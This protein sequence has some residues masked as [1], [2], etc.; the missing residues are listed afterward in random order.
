VDHPERLQLWNLWRVGK[1]LLTSLQQ[2][3]VESGGRL[4][5]QARYC[6]KI[7]GE[8]VGN[9]GKGVKEARREELMWA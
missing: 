3:L 9:K 5:E 1:S 6:G 2:R 7:A 4:V 8:P